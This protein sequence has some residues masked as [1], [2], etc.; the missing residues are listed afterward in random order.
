[1]DEAVFAEINTDVGKTAPQ[2]VIEHQ[3]ARLKF[4]RVHFLAKSAHFLGR[5]WQLCAP[6][7]PENKSHEPA[8]VHAAFRLRSAILIT[9][10]EHAKRA[11]NQLRRTRSEV[12]NPR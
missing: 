1:M 2:R 11:H 10:A 5:A 3:V 6:G 4:A 9:D 8:A 7:I 12:V